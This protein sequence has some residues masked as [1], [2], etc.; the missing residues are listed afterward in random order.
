MNSDKKVN[1]VQMVIKNHPAVVFLLI[2]I[3][4]TWGCSSTSFHGVDRIDLVNAGEE[5]AAPPAEGAPDMAKTVKDL[6]LQEQ[7]DKSAARQY[8]GEAMKLKE[9]MQYEAAQRK[10]ERAVQLDPSYA[11]AQKE[12]DEVRFLLD[13]VPPGDR[14]AA[15]DDFIK[16]QQMRIQE[17]QAQL[18]RLFS[19]GEA[20]M[21]REEYTEAAKKYQRVIEI[22]RFYPWNLNKPELVALAAKRREQA[23]GNAKD[24]EVYE[25]R[26][27]EEEIRELAEYKRAYDLKYI[28]NRIQELTRRAN[29]SFQ[30]GQ[31]D[32]TKIL[33]KHILSLDP[34]NEPAQNLLR[35][36]RYIQHIILQDQIQ[37]ETARNKDLI[38]K[39]IKEASIPYQ[40]LFRFPP[41]KEWEKLGAETVSLEQRIR[42]QEPIENRNIHRVLQQTKIP[43][44]S[45]ENSPLDEVLNYLKTISNI[46]FVLNKSAQDAV[47]MGGLTVD[48][49]EVTNLTLQNVLELILEGLG[50]TGYGY[51]IQNG[52]VVIGPADSLKSKMY[53]EFYI[54]SDIS[55]PH[56]D[57]PA[58]EL[59]I[60]LTS[61]AGG[62]GGGGML[63]DFADMGMGDEEGPKG[64]TIGPQ[65]LVELIDKRI[66]GSDPEKGTVKHQGGQLVVR[67]SLENHAK[68]RELLESLRKM[69]G[70][71]VSVESRFLDLQDNLLDEIG[72][73]IGG[74]VESALE[75][76][77]PDVNGL[78]T[79]VASGYAFIEKNTLYET[80]AAVISD[81]T[82]F[83]GTEVTPFNI[84]SRGGMALQWNYL[85]KYQL[86]AILTTVEKSQKSQTLDAPRVL[87]FDNQ[88]AH[89]MVIDQ[90]A[91]IKDV[92][93]NQTGVSPVINPLIGSFR[94]G[95]MLEIR[96]TVTH[97]QKYVI[98]EVKPTSAVHIDSEYAQLSLAAG[99][100]MVQ[101][102]LPVI[103]L[104][105]INTTITIPDGGTVLVG[106]LKKVIEQ[107]RSI[108][109]PIIQRIPVLN[110]LFGRR[111]QTRLNN[112]LFILIKADILSVKEKE[113][114]NFP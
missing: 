39:G 27:R 4:M 70:V 109:I 91:Y 28:Q 68:I 63:E 92:D 86:E 69:S 29:D 51:Q 107:T 11:E 87:A 99:N 10:L 21:A 59:S 33:C 16:N 12:L 50:D 22:N 52:A 101:V 89:T 44:I 25:R 85:D 103:L 96:P 94:V 71:L 56:P 73:D 84:S 6:T 112:N 49:A 76:P 62:A 20:L 24:K 31:Y 95:S 110:L 18:E 67:T 65:Q 43:S 102:E 66:F 104:Y 5:D 37:R 7:A 17:A 93:V 77:I 61:D 32:K 45:F 80:R 48:L 23:L 98:L 41:R 46:S 88:I 57:F 42:D 81:Y 90:I 47:E 8:Y 97:D 36:A 58:P 9:S 19:E 38:M 35:R 55:K 106:G 75:Y 114:L 2:G 15:T 64:G 113:K 53:T 74:P 108:G 83:L 54:I 3:L 30:E 105:Q 79:S 78:G 13:D 72:V 111:G 14:G 1:V 40:D 60:R 82:G 34:K 100:T 26:K